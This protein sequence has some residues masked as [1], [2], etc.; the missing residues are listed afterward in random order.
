MRL[1]KIKIPFL[2]VSFIL[3]SNK[4]Y[5]GYS[6]FWM[7]GRNGGIQGNLSNWI[8]YSIVVVI[9]LST[10]TTIVIWKSYLSEW[11]LKKSI[12]NDAIWDI[13]N[14]KSHTRESIRRLNDSIQN[15]D[16]SKVSDLLTTE[17]FDEL[18][19]GVLELTKKGEKNILRCNII[20]VL[21]IIGC[22]DYKNNSFDKYVAY[23]QGYMLDYTISEKTGEIIKNKKRQVWKFSHTYHF[24]RVE[25]QWKLEKINN[26]ASTLDV[27][28]TKNLFEK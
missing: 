24:I 12:R 25:N 28:K 27:L 6:S 10:V 16:L 5:A 13:E 2:F 1:K 18:N 23:I 20:R 4:V 8:G 14:L 3:L 11:I 15:K 7:I 19:S 17:L 22:E 9:I 21:E 26:S